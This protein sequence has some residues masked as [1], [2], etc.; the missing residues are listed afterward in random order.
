MHYLCTIV[1]GT[2]H[3]FEQRCSANYV[4]GVTYIRIRNPSGISIH[5]QN[6]V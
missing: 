3:L 4:N 5:A 2:E 6:K 1:C